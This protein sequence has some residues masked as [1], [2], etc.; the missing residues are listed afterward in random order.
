MLQRQFS[1]CGSCTYSPHPTIVQDM[2]N[3][4]RLFR[5]IFVSLLERFDI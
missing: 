1:T 5:I 2:L 3:Q 4:S